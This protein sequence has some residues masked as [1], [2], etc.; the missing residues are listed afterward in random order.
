MSDG[1]LGAAFEKLQPQIA[2]CIAALVNVRNK[3][4]GYMRGK[5]IAGHNAFNSSPFTQE[6]NRTLNALRITLTTFFSFDATRK[7][8]TPLQPP[9]V[10]TT[11]IIGDKTLCTR[12][13]RLLQM[14]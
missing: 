12:N 2:A 3:A 11:R 13:T 4:G 1:T 14:K 10:N 7:H 6:G 8:A 5:G 9:E